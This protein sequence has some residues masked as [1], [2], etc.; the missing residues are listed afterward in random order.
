MMSI[1]PFAAHQPYSLLSFSV[2]DGCG[3]IQKAGHIPASAGVCM[4]ASM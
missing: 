4:R 2:P 1:S 3:S